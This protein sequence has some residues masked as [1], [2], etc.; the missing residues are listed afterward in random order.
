MRAGEGAAA[1]AGELVGPRVIVGKGF[2]S[3]GQN[4]AVVV[5]GVASLRDAVYFEVLY[6]IQIIVTIVKCFAGCGA[7]NMARLRR[8]LKF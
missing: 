2:A 5:I 8:L 6:S 1:V 7:V 3:H 4:V